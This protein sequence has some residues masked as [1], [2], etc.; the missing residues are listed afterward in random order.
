MNQPQMKMDI[1]IE[2][3]SF[4]VEI[5]PTIREDNIKAFVNWVFSTNKG[6]IKIK[7]GTI[8]LKQ[9]G[10]KEL[11]SYDLP[12]VRLKVGFVKVFY[13]GNKELYKSLCEFTIK[14]YCQETGELPNKITPDV[15]EEIDLEDLPF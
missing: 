2:I 12:A 13:M 14:T 4:F 1:S 15:G 8:R 6:E 11:L 5:R 9:F 10:K 3:K 7:Q